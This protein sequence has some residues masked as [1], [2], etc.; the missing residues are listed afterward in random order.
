[1]TKPVEEHACAEIMRALVGN[2]PAQDDIAVLALSRAFLHPD[3]VSAVP[4]SA[5]SGGRRTAHRARADRKRETPLGVN[6]WQEG[7]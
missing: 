1:M 5:T 3:A 7:Q 6:E 2:T 4:I